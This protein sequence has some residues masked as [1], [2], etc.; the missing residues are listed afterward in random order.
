MDIALAALVGIVILAVA[1]G[2]GGRAVANRAAEFAAEREAA[3]DD[4]RAEAELRAE[5]AREARS[6][7]H[8]RRIETVR[9]MREGNRLRHINVTDDRLVADLNPVPT[10]REIPDDALDYEYTE[11]GG[12]R[13][14]K[15]EPAPAVVAYNR[16]RP[17]TPSRIEY[18]YYDSP[19]AAA[20][21]RH[22]GIGGG[23]DEVA[24][25]PPAGGHPLRAR[26]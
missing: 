9:L 16:S 11:R 13:M 1:A 7:T 23:H 17:A 6:Q 24:D 3:A 20:A 5:R 12:I 2:L 10:E 4:R 18:H 26:L 21:D 25:H 8:E 22:A 14:R 19:R 15:Y